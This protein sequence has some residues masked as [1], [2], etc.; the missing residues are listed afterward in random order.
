AAAAGDLD[1]ARLSAEA[2]LA[3]PVGAAPDDEVTGDLAA[4]AIEDQ[5]AAKEL[6][7][8]ASQ[9][10]GDH[11]RALE[12]LEPLLERRPDDEDLLAQVLRSEAVARGVPAALARYAAYDERTRD[13]LGAEP[14]DR[15]RR[16]HLDLLAREAPVREGLTYD[17]VPMVGRDHD[18]TSIRELLDGGRVV[19][20]VGPGG[21]GKTRMAHLVGHLAEQPVVRLVELAG[22]SD[23]DGL[24]P[25][26]AG[27]LGVRDAVSKPLQ[28]GTAPDL[29]GRIAQQL[30]GAPTLLVVDNCEHLVEAVADLVAF[31]VGTVPDLRVL[32][33]SRSPL[34]IAAERVFLLPQLEPDAA[35]EVFR[36][37][38]LAARPGVRLDEDEVRRLVERLDG[39]PLAIELAA[40]KVRVMSVAEVARRLGDRFG[41]LRGGDRAAPDRHQTLEAVIEW[42]WQLLPASPRQAMRALS[43]FPDGFS[44]GGAEAVLGREALT[45]IGH[46]AE[47]SLLVVRED[48]EMR[49]RFLETVREFAMQRLGETGEREAVE[50]RLSEWAVTYARSKAGGLSGPAQIAT[51]TALREEAGNLTG[52]LRRAIDSGDAETVVPLLATM[53]PYWTIRGDHGSVFS[54]AAP[55]QELL[56]NVQPG[57]TRPDELRTVL[58]DLAMGQIILGGQ[59]LQPSLDR[60]RELGPGEPGSRGYGITKVLLAMFGEDD[61]K[62][63][64][65]LADDEDRIVSLTALVWLCQVQENSGELDAARATSRRALAKID[66]DDGPWVRAMAESQMAGL[67][68]QHGD[69]DLALESMRRALPTMEALGSVDDCVQLRSFEALA[70]LGRG[71]VAA[72]ERALDAVANDERARRSLA[73]IFGAN[74]LAELALAKGEIERG[75]ELYRESVAAARART[76]PGLELDIELTPWVLFSQS[77]ALVA[78][79]QHD[80]AT[81]A[82]DL[83][84]EL[85]RRLPELF[86][87]GDRRLDIPVVGGVL[88]AVG[89]WRLVVGTGDPTDAV[90]LLVLADRFGYYRGIPSMSWDRASALA[91]RVAPGALA[92]VEDEYAGRRA[93]DL[94]EDAAAVVQSAL[95]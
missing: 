94:L 1:L 64:E 60:M 48:D 27:V 36:Q 12:L 40:A 72:A 43:V 33:T 5:A 62:P 85:E 59:A 79:I 22:V 67:A 88:C 57:A 20:I 45:D 42:S 77:C 17:A 50:E 8:A 31:L 15:L 10:R 46:L 89:Q 75:V 16:L 53:A 37:R 86:E 39:L 11:V 52:V 14:G 4:E 70:E 55:V 63:L 34:G 18:V 2:A 29:R 78:H 6:L 69:T 25:E 83:A 80:L 13:R 76:V 82:A 90:R 93:T 24:L 68:F 26:V 66:D 56:A 81:H 21:L 19:S 73:W 38:A 54:L 51:V 65:E 35:V 92:L 32:T 84:S 74:G 9:A 61:T 23:P 91:E 30:L 41:L 58:A 47:Q 3:I 49:Y 95:R 7:G 44:L 71:D 28:Q 87:M